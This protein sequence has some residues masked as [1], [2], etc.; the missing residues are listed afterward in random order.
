MGRDTDKDRFDAEYSAATDWMAENDAKKDEIKSLLPPKGYQTFMEVWDEI[1]GRW[2]LELQDD[3]D[4]VKQRELFEELV[5]IFM[6]Y[7]HGTKS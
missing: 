5:S 4:G 2:E 7:P 6:K 1:E 3:N